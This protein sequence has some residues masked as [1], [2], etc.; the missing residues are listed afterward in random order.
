[1]EEV[2]PGATCGKMLGGIVI[3]LSDQSTV[4]E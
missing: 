1:M 3:L 2:D 4:V